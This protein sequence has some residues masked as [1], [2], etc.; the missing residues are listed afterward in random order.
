[1]AIKLLESLPNEE[2]D[3]AQQVDDGAAINFQAAHAQNGALWGCTLSN[4]STTIS[5]SAGLLMVRGYR[6]KVD[7]P[8]LIKN[9]SSGSYPVFNTTYYLWLKI[10]RS[11]SNATFTWEANFGD[12][13]PSQ[14]AIERVEGTF[15][16]KAAKL[17]LGPS[18]IVGTVTSLI[19]VIPA[20]SGTTSSSTREGLDLPEPSIELVSSAEEQT[21]GSNKGM[22]RAYL[23]LANKDLYSKYTGVYTVR[24][25]LFRYLQKGRMRSRAN[26][27]ILRTNK[28]GFVR[29]VTTLGWRVNASTMKT[30]I[31]YT[32]LAT[33]TIA[34]SGSYNYR[35][36]DVIDTI[37]NY[38]DNAFYYENPITG[39]KEQVTGI[40]QEVA[41]I[42]AT[43][44][45]ALGLTRTTE[46][47]H[48]FFKFAFKAE[49]YDSNNKRVAVSDFS[50]TITIV[51]NRAHED[52]LSTTPGGYGQLFKI[53][54]D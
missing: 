17:T 37:Y 51:P 43:R 27:N 7:G 5:I 49:L 40:G 8:T 34:V 23:C 41:Y 22:T 39:A 31:P 44:S 30:S 42:R 20:A 4:S 35:R 36:T 25:V 54:I 24:F 2:N 52:I 48:N 12:T 47:K 21:P 13:A 16:Y 29:P 10:V 14:T 6:F 18:G 33:V 45:K 53:R 19:A 32:S 38:I 15:W 26:G 46:F 11:G 50:P 3:V 28:T 1:M 9:F